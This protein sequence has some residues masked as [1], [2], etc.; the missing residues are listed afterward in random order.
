[1]W[2]SFI[3]EREIMA[4]K[5]LLAHCILQRI[6]QEELKRKITAEVFVHVFALFLT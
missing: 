3:Q 1:M 2:A 6:T 5:G 4:K